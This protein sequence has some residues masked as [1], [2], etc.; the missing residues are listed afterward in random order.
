MAKTRSGK[1]RHLRLLAELRQLVARHSYTMAPLFNP[2]AVYDHGRTHGVRLS[3][4]GRRRA[5]GSALWGQ[6]KRLCYVTADSD[7]SGEWMEI[8]AT[9]VFQAGIYYCGTCASRSSGPPAPTP[10]TIITVCVDGREYRVRAAQVRQWANAK[11]QQ[12]ALRRKAADRD[13]RRA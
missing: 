1:L 5:G 11:A 8:E 6:M 7:P 3:S 4:D 9:S 10:A 2:I 13:G 12:D